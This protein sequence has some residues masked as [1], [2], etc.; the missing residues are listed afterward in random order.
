MSGL[1]KKTLSG[2]KGYGSKRRL[3]V[4]LLNSANFLERQRSGNLKRRA[5]VGHIQRHAIENAMRLSRTDPSYA[6]PTRNA[7]N[8][9][10]ALVI[11]TAVAAADVSVVTNESNNF[12]S[13]FCVDLTEKILAASSSCSIPVACLASSSSSDL[14]TLMHN[15]TGHGNLRMLIESAKSKLVTGL[16]IEDSHIRKF[17]QDD[18]HVCD[19]CARA[20]ITRQ[21]FK[22]NH[23]VRGKLLGDYISCDIAVFKNC[24]SREGY[25][26][27]I[28]FLDHATKYCWVYPM[29]TR[30]ESIEKLRDL[31]DVQLKRF[32]VK[33]KHYHADGA[34]ELIG[35]QVVQILKREGATYSWNPAETPELNATTERKFRTLGERTLCMILPDCL[36]TSGG[37]PMRQVII[38]LIDYRRRRHV[39]IKRLTRAC[40]VKFLICHCY[41]Y[42]GV[43]LI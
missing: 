14:L 8:A 33:I 3:I 39:D 24:P 29:K 7:K 2:I 15:R 27:V 31:V 25:L 40:L 4:M 12:Y 36:W 1:Q 30:D 34:A 41:E 38:L 13:N 6:I 43:R 18:K 23:K 32:Q 17:R 26:Y 21:S 5:E 10:N 42:G 37:T 35:K 19:I 28:Q 20:K 22:K 16:Q 11:D 9:K